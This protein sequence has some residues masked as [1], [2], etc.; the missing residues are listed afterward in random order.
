MPPEPDLIAAV[1]PVFEEQGA[2]GPTL[3][4]LP[5]DVVGHAI[6]VDGGSRDGTAAEAR[7]AGG[8]VILE[9]RRGY[10][11]ACASGV[12]EARRHGAAIVLFLDGDG[13][14]EVERAADIAGPVQRDE[15]DLVLA[16]RSAP[17]REPGSMGRHQ[18]FAGWSIGLLSRLLTGTRYR[19]MS[20]FRAIRIDRLGSLG[21]TE[22][23][24]GWNLEM[25]LRAA[26]AGLRVREIELP[27]RCRRAGASKVA[28]NWRG[29]I[30]T[31]LRLAAVLSRTGR[32][33]LAGGR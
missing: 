26:H 16:W 17:G 28:G 6:V 13:S 14:D 2:I 30:R 22:M 11:R 20:A 29:T 31:T 3:R 1:I 33:V 23:T 7:D 8:S 12:A 4:R 9:T 32:A 5:R 15:A 18:V 21:M 19:D 24:Y 25:Q 10:G 27:Y